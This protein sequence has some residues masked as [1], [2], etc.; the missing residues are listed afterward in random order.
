MT[1]LQAAMQQLVGW[2]EDND[3]LDRL[4][5][6]LTLHCSEDNVPDPATGT[7]EANR[8]FELLREAAEFEFEFDL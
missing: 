3:T 8:I 2:L 5:A 6:H 1:E 4:A 7:N